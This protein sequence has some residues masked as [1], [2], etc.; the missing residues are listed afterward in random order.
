M[1]QQQQLD[2][3]MNAHP[4]DAYESSHDRWDAIAEGVEGKGMR[5][6]VARYSELRESLMKKERDEQKAYWDTVSDM[7][8]DVPDGVMDKYNELDDEIL[9]ASDDDD[10]EEQAAGTAMAV[11]LNPEQRGTVVGLSGYQMGGLATL[12]VETLSALFSC[13]RCKSTTEV[14]LSGRDAQEADKKIWCDNCSTLMSINLRPTL[15]T[16]AS[17]SLCYLGKSYPFVFIRGVIL[18]LPYRRSRQ[19]LPGRCPSHCA[20]GCLR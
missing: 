9:S 12:Q 4:A 20:H 1:N 13:C 3:A 18:F 11:E 6:C 2:D 7:G 10:D 19:V 5:Q 14:A 17:A 15:L 16:E 8:G